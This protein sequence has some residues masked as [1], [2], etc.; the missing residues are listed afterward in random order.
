MKFYIVG[1]LQEVVLRFEFHQ[2]RSELWGRNLPFPI[3][4]AIGLYK[5]VISQQIKEILANGHEKLNRLMI[6]HTPWL[7]PA[8]N[9]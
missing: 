8:Q 6:A 5:I 9:Y 4:S 2:N 3:D 7:L 1:G